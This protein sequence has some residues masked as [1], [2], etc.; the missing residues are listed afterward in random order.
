[1]KRLLLLFVIPLFAIL[2]A[3]SSLKKDVLIIGDSISIGYTPFVA[4]ALADVATVVRH[5][6]NAQMSAN[7]VERID[8]WLGDTKWDVIHFNFGLWDLCYRHPESKVQGNR[9]KVNGE[10]T[11]TVEEYAANLE[12]IVERLERTGAK[13]I[14][15][16]TTYVPTEEEGRFVEDVERYNRV[17]KEIMKRHK[18]KINPLYDLSVKVHPQYGNGDDDVHYSEQGYEAL[19]K[20]VAKYIRREL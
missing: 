4:E 18:I 14:F 6:G 1:M 7:G 5:E 12:I 8:K 2:M 3:A 16:T 11:A 20:Q 19:S 9:D 15:A 17:A 13:L 10:L